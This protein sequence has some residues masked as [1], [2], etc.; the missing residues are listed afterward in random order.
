MI[1]E[2]KETLETLLL[3]Q[4]LFYE[5]TKPYNTYAKVNISLCYSR[6]NHLQQRNVA[7]KPPFI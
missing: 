7:V 4:A 5:K 1:N 6:S 2:R 3:Q